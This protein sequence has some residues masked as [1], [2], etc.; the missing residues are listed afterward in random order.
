MYLWIG[1]N[2]SP[3]VLQSLFGTPQIQQINIEKSKLSDID[4]PLSKTVR[5]VI[6]KVN[7]QRSSML[8]VCIS[9]NNSSYS[10]HSIL[11]FFFFFI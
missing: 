4:T 9:I 1:S 2:V 3:T 11:S 10:I 7:E 6:N 8:R 5:S